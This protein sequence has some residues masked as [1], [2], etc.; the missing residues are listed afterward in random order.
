[1]IRPDAVG[2]LEDPALLRAMPRYAKVVKGQLPARYAMA[3]AVGASFSEDASDEDLLK[4]H[5]ILLG[6]EA[7][8]METTDKGEASV[9]HAKPRHSLLGL[10]T[11]LGSRVM[12]KCHLCERKCQVN[13]AKGELGYCRLG[14][15][16][17]VSSSFV[18][19]G[20]EPEIVPSFTVCGQ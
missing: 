19:M 1:M 13:R 11:L 20:E 8:L 5:D 2:V 10:K 7:R 15:G 14:D 16:M 17:R 6:E 3:R 12:A 9:R 4:E 18:H